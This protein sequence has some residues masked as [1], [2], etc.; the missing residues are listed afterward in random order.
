MHIRKVLSKREVLKDISFEVASGDIFGYLGPNGAGKT[1]SI[2]IIL[3]LLRSDSGQVTILGHD[4]KVDETRRRV[5]FVLEADGLYE[6]MTAL[7]NLVYYARIYGVTRP[8]ER[9]N[10]VLSQ[11][12]LKD[13][14]RDKVLA[15]SKGMRQRLSLAR[16][17]L[18]DPDVL[19][20]DEPTAGVDP[21]GQIEVRRIILDMSRNEG[22]TI[23]FSSHNLDE[24]Q[25]IC[26]R[27]AL[28]DRGEIKI[29]GRLEDIQRSMNRGGL[30][31]DISLPVPDYITV[32][33]VSLFQASLV[34]QS[35]R[36]LVLK[37]TP[38]TSV[39]DVVNFL[40]SRGVR[41]EQVRRD[42]AS[43]EDIYS[44]IFREAEVVK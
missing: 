23:L 22:K 8:T 38:D 10:E 5:G 28:I 25:R 16:A 13:R 15:Y 29:Y 17:I 2:R 42:D 26:N 37:L 9:I 19:V 6:N 41:I 27:I 40:C 32:E 21:T 31:I 24:V 43:L 14:V 36:Q 33:L 39:P 12:G 44:T 35:D 30:T 4:V 20:L 18:H 3:G 1:T 11:V 34:Q 7:D